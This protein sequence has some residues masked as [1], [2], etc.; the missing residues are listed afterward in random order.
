MYGWVRHVFCKFV[1]VFYFAR[2]VMGSNTFWE[3]SECL[4]TSQYIGHVGYPL[5]F[6]AFF[7]WEGGVSCGGRGVMALCSSRSKIEG[8]L[9]VALFKIHTTFVLFVRGAAGQGK[10]WHTLKRAGGKLPA[11]GKTRGVSRKFEDDR[12]CPVRYWLW[13]VE[14]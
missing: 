9:L 1:V 10:S 13:F 2:I 8:A 11:R 6:K 14:R 12:I 7:K 5:Y 3:G 4:A